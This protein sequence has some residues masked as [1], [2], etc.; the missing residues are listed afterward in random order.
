MSGD[1][2]F[3]DCECVDAKRERCPHSWGFEFTHARTRW[4]ITL[5]AHLKYHPDKR[6]PDGHVTAKTDVR[7]LGEEIRVAIRA[8]SYEKRPA[9]PAM[10]SSQAATTGDRTFDELRD[11][12]ADKVLKVGRKGKPAPLTWSNNAGMLRK[13]SVVPVR[14]PRTLGSL[15]VAAID[16][17]AVETAFDVCVEDA[18]NGTRRKYRGVIF[19]FFHWLVKRGYLAA[20]PL[21]DDVNLDTGGDDHMR[22]VRVPRAVEADLIEAANEGRTGACSTRLGGMVVVALECGLRHGEMLAL[23][24]QDRKRTRD[25]LRFLEVAAVEQGGRKTKVSR[26]VPETPRVTA[27]LDYLSIA[28]TGDSFRPADYLF[29]DLDGSRVQEV[30]KAWKTAV[31]RAHRITP[32]WTSTGG[33]DDRSKAA[34]KALNDGEGLWWT[35]LRHE[36]AIRWHESGLPLATIAQLLGHSN[37]KMLEV[38]LGITGQDALATHAR[39]MADV[40]STPVDIRG[41]DGAIVRLNLA[42]VPG[43]LPETRKRRLGT[44]TSDRANIH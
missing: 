29:G 41:R 7:T 44:S 34:F 26:V 5:D 1:G 19:R 8:G 35:D 39:I 38:Y 3:K 40:P 28:P 18:A 4:R 25:G 23:R 15:A 32:G 11:M 42:E 37:L 6:W 9:K 2:Y 27:I 13:L 30:K 17:D 24:H 33:L 36:C 43:K 21:T 12:F 22:R 16:E 31:L 14:G 10:E 20:S